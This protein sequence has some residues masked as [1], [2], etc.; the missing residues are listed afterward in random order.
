LRGLIDLIEA[1]KLQQ[2]LEGEVPLRVEFDELRDKNV[3]NALTLKNAAYRRTGNIRL[4]TSKLTS[5]PSGSAPTMP[6]VPRDPSA[7]IA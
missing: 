4:F 5:V 2:F 6:H 3:G 7:S 1:V